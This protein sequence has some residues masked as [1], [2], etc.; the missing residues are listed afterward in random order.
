MEIPQSL[1]IKCQEPWNT[2]IGNGT[3]TIEG[4]IGSQSRFEQYVNSV[5]TVGGHKVI[6]EKVKHYDDL[7]SYL[8]ECWK[9]AAPHAVDL[10]DAIYKYLSVYDTEKEIQVFNSERILKE[11]GICALYIK[12]I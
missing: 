2:Y 10:D 8:Y 11:G 6:L 1:N 7:H 4:R 5:I 12:L 3:K 9:K